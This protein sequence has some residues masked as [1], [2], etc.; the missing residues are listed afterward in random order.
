MEITGREICSSN[1]VQDKTRT[2]SQI[3]ERVTA[4]LSHGK[5]S[6]IS[7]SRCSD[8][9]QIDPDFKINHTIV[10]SVKTKNVIE[11]E[12]ISSCATDKEIIIYAAD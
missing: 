12:G 6:E 3:N 8:K 7:I 9:E 5:R 1:T 10:P 11:Q 2:I 4:H